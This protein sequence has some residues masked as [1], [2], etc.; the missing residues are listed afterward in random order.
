MFLTYTTVVHEK[1]TLSARSNV[2]TVP[3]TVSAVR[4]ACVAEAI[5]Y[6]SRKQ[7]TSDGH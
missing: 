6:D 7:T 4:R 3:S 1:T 5:E 2:D